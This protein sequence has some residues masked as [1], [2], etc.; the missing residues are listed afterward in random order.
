MNA[1]DA[2]EQSMRKRAEL[3]NA[4]ILDAIANGD[5]QIKWNYPLG[6]LEKEELKSKGFK[7]NEVSDKFGF[8]Y[9]LISW[10]QK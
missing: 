10:D 3:L 6:K 9:N 7:V 5:I 2:Y 8:V 4:R 1:K